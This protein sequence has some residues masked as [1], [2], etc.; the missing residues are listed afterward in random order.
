MF[1]APTITPS[2]I[3]S[4]VPTI[5]CLMTLNN[6]FTCLRAAFTKSNWGHRFYRHPC[7]QSICIIL[8]IDG[9]RKFRSRSELVTTNTDENAIAAAE[10]IGLSKIA[11]NGYSTPAAIGIPA[12]L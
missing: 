2:A 6:F 5:A 8:Q 10:I 3:A 12:M 9:A 7:P 1:E 4:I 11:K